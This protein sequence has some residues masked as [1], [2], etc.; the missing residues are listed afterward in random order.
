MFVRKLGDDVGPALAGKAVFLQ[1][2]IQRQSRPL[3]G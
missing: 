3:P 2:K 1:M